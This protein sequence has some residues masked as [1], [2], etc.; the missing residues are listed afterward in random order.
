MLRWMPRSDSAPEGPSLMDRLLR[1]RGFESPEAARA[2]LRPSRAQLEDPFRMPGMRAAAERIDAARRSGRVIWVYG[3]YDVDGV[4]AAAILTRF[5]AALGA[6][7]RAYIPSRHSEGYGLNAEAIRKIAGEDEKPLLVT[8]DCGVTAAEEIELA[9]ELGL[10]PIVTD[11]HRPEERLPDCP[12]VNPLLG[13]PFPALCGAGVAFKLCQALDDKAAYE[14]I[15]L[16]ALGTV[17]DVVPLTGE[18]RAI[19]ALGLARINARPRPGLR[20]LMRQAGVKPGEVTAGKIAFQLAPRLNAGGRVDSALDSLALLTAETEAEAEPLASTLEEKNQERKR[21]E[22]EILEGAEAQLREFDFASR[23]V[24]ALAGEGWNAGVLGLA[25]SRLVEKYN[26]PT[27]LMRREGGVLHGSCRSIPG[28]DIFKMLTAVSGLLTRFGG[29]GQAAGLTLAEENLPAFCGALDDAIS[30]AADPESF[31]P[32]ARYDMALPLSRLEDDFVSS[33]ALFEPTGFGNPA[34]VFLTEA[35]IE[36]REAV[37]AE[38][39]HLRL[40]LRDGGKSLPGIAFSM[41]PRAG[42]LPE[43]A[44]VRALYAPRVSAF[45]GQEYVDCQV[46]EIGPLDCEGAFLASGSD[47]DRAF[48]TFLTN[49]LYNKA[50]SAPADGVWRGFDEIFAALKDS[51]RGT[52]VLAATED[53]ALPFLRA[54][55]ERAPDRMDVSVGAFP[56]DRRAFN[57]FCLL[58][59]GEPPS[60][61]PRRFSLDAP[62][63][64]WAYPVLE[65][66]LPPPG[67]VPF[68][69]VDGLRR[70]FV[71]ARD[72]ARRPSATKAL[73]EVAKDLGTEAGLPACTAFAA[74]TILA[75]MNLIVLR[76]ERPFVEVP[77]PRKADPNDNPAFQWMRRMSRWGGE[78]LDT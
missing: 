66:E 39:A 25:A 5:L 70:V 9:K 53:A 62:S 69:D 33:L 27:V 45:R 15:D 7:T 6:R 16:A 55:K 13:Y 72:L 65:P 10:D 59:P 38:K 22:R 2:F 12:V 61:Y 46:R 73:N 42:S 68:P 71:A 77:P 52:L 28:V 67:G 19:T 3:D 32:A 41:G 40:R 64:F 26:L 57:A 29:H 8:V 60:G 1:A 56:D 4:T 31:V 35:V 50:Y 76:D 43:G 44:R 58:P 74:L 51:P 20:A 37:G 17:A 75:D 23:R 48:Q 49:R 11:H 34:P 14:W 63:S 54:A 21:L 30:R 18:N 47:F 24:I 36:S 78:P